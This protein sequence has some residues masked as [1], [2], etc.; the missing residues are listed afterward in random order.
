[1]PQAPDVQDWIGH[2]AVDSSGDKIGSIEAIYV[3]DQSGQ[4]EWVAVKTGLFGS[5]L[6]FVP[7]QGA[8]RQD[9]DAPRRSSASAPGPVRP[10]RC[11]SGSTWSPGTSPRPC[12]CSAKRSDP[13]W[14]STVRVRGG[15][16]SM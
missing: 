2:N 8:T 9:D 11:G 15:L 14:S 1:M 12:P 16:E 6:S 7:I 5:N 13:F 10:A 3:D 4:P